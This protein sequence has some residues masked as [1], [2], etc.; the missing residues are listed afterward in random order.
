MAAALT[1]LLPAF[2]SIAR[3]DD[4]VRIRGL[5]R[6]RWIDYPR[7]LQAIEKLERLVQTPPR[8]RMPC[9]L[10][11]GDSNIG[12]T[13]II[14]RFQRRY[15]PEFDAKAGVEE[16]K[17]VVMQ[18]PPTPEQRRFYAALL[19]ELGAS[20]NASAKLSVLENLSREL[21]R[22]ASSRMLVV[23]EVHHLLAGNYREQR[24]SLNLL[25]YLANDLRMSIVLV[26]TRDA[27]IALQTDAQISSRF[28]RFEVPRWQESAAFR[29][30][31]SAFERILPLRRASNL[32]RR[33]MVT[34]VLAASGGLTGEVSRLLNVA[35]E[36]AILDGREMIDL[37]HIEQA[38]C[39]GL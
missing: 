30:L 17:V 25:K 32:A 20:F 2:R 34:T 13:Q 33:E 11:Y 26:G 21:L 27:E 7:A 36:L 23:D 6:E 24:A 37:S 31:L 9:L 38:R 35:A 5:A 14:G 19:F 16:R 4:K 29:G 12:K 39:A 10:L 1:H 8:D 22:R 18:M 3:S 28:A 15:P